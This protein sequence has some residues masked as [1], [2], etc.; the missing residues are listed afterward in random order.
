MGTPDDGTRLEEGEAFGP[1]ADKLGSGE[2]YS[3]PGDGPGDG[4]A[5]DIAAIARGTADDEAAINET[6][7]HVEALLRAERGSGHSPAVPMSAFE[8]PPQGDSPGE[9]GDIPQEQ[10]AGVGGDYA[11]QTAADDLLEGIVEAG[12]R[13]VADLDRRAATI[14]ETLNVLGAAGEPVIADIA[15]LAEELV[16]IREL[17]PQLV[18]WLNTI[19]TLGSGTP[20]NVLV[21]V[22]TQASAIRAVVE[23]QRQALPASPLWD[24]RFFKSIERKLPWLAPAL[25]TRR[26]LREWTFTAEAG[27]PILKAQISATFE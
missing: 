6:K 2:E 25:T 23:R 1:V 16:Q 11:A 18:A 8:L 7:A 10:L 26:S 22:M 24:S 3:E 20:A 21:Y 17:R 9:R 15:D 27:L 14:L 19:A 13:D 12:R 5:L 4:E